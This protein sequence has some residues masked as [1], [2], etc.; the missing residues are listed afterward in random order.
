MFAPATQFGKAVH[1]I[2]LHPQRSAL[3]SITLAM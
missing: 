3:P 1:I 2:V